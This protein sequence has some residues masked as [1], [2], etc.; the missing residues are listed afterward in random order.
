MRRIPTGL[1]VRL[2][3]QKAPQIKVDRW[4]ARKTKFYNPQGVCQVCQ[5]PVSK[6][7]LTCHGCLEDASWLT[8][9]EQDYHDTLAS[10]RADWYR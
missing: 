10:I 8:Q 9:Q 5:K 7:Q 4:Q 3:R 1:S 6:H 2:N